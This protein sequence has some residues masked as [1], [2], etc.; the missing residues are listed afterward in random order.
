MEKLNGKKKLLVSVFISGRGTNLKSLIN[1]SKRKNSPIK[2]V[3]IITNNKN[4]KGLY[5]AKKNKI[6]F[7]I[8]NYKNKIKAE[9]KILLNLKNYK[10]SLICLA[11]F[12]KILSKKIINNYKDR[13]LNIHPSLLPKYKGLNTHKR[14]IKN[15]EKFSGCTVHVVN[16]KLDS[17]KIILQKK[18]RILKKD[19]E[20]SLS[21]RVLKIENLIYPKAI[22]KFIFSNL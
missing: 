2:I 18:I 5:F 15:N 9:N 19:D 6:K 17:G 7:L 3:L 11:G 10:V 22:K 4:A 21:K 8:I 13:I 20:N 14:V 16:S 12:M 1:F